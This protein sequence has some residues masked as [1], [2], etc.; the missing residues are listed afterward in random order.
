MTLDPDPLGHKKLAR[1][2]PVMRALIKQYGPCPITHKP[3]VEPYQSLMQA[4][5]SQQLSTKA[6]DT[7]FAR[8]LALFPGGFPTPRQMLKLDATLL[9]AAGLSEN[10]KLAMLDIAQKT[11]DGVVPKAGEIDHLSDDEIVERLTAVRGIGRWSVEMFLI[12]TLGRPDVWP[13]D[14][15]GVRK[16]YAA[17]Y[18]APMPTPKELMTIGDAWRPHRSLATWLFWRACE[19]PLNAIAPKSIAAPPKASPSAPKGEMLKK[20]RAK[21]KSLNK[22]SPKSGPREIR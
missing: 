7:I 15:L 5:V 21:S 20:P 13:V 10:K 8:V 3:H 17:A 18:G 16:G 4:V 19:N 2:D 1:K 22:P 9:R 12:F 11:L 14:D 6:A